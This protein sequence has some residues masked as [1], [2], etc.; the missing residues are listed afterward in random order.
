MDALDWQNVLIGVRLWLSGGNPY[1]P[2]VGVHDQPVPA[3]WFAYPP[4]ALYLLAPFALLPMWL[5]T[6]LWSFL[7]LVGL[8]R[9]MRAE[10]G[11]SAVVALLWWP[12]IDHISLGQFS[13]PCLLLVSAV[14][15][16]W[17][18]P[19]L[20]WYGPPL[21]A[22]A[23]FKPQIA[24]LPLLIIGY[25]AFRERRWRFLLATGGWLAGLW[26]LPLWFNGIA[27][28]QIWIDTILHRRDALLKD[29]GIAPLLVVAA[30]ILWWQTTRRRDIFY[31][32][33]GLMTLFIPVG[34]TYSLVGLLFPAAITRRPMPFWALGV[35]YIAAIDTG[36]R[37]A[38]LHMQIVVSLVGLLLALALVW[39]ED[40]G[41]I[42]RDVA[43]VL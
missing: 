19:R 29:F 15:A 11:R 24:A 38:A 43:E 9:W 10:T 1:T 22:L 39:R 18:A 41:V 34:H 26:A 35:S 20:T 16:R 33:I 36:L 12:V 25:R 31:G 3:Y 13:L 21:L 27:I 8:D 17:S 42:P 32:A 28:Y 6:F 7:T 30:A 37:L 4:P 5:S 2:F 14:W 40:A 23:T